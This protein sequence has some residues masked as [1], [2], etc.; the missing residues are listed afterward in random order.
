MRVLYISSRFGAPHVVA[1]QQPVLRYT[2]THPNRA[3][4]VTS[5]DPAHIS[6]E[7]LRCR[8][9]QPCASIDAKSTRPNKQPWR[10]RLRSP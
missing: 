1:A 7:H 6:A 8:R 2:H 9:R 4:Q 3:E 10:A 5:T